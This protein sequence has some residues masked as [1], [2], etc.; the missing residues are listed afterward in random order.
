MA[1]ALSEA[2]TEGP[3]PTEAADPAAGAGVGATAGDAMDAPRLAMYELLFD[4]VCAADLPDD[5]ADVLLAAYEGDRQLA[6][7]LH[8][9]VTTRAPSARRPAGPGE[10][11]GIYLRS[12][13]VE[14]FRGIGRET[15]LPLRPGPGLTLVMGRNGSGKSSFAEAAE[16]VMTGDSFRWADRDGGAVWRGGWRNFHAGQDTETH[17]EVDLTVEGEHRPV[18][19]ERRWPAGDA[20]EDGTSTVQRAGARRELLADQDWPAI[21][22]T[23]RPF[24]SYAELGKLV[25]GRPSEMYDA[26]HAIL[27]LEQLVA[28]EA[29]LTTA[30]KDLDAR[31]KAVKQDLGRLREDLASCS[32]ERAARVAAALGGRRPDLDT[33]ESITTGTADPEPAGTLTDLT[34]ITLPTADAV[35]AQVHDL[36]EAAAAARQLAGTP[37][38]E[39]SRLADLL[40]RALEHHEAHGDGPCPVCGAGRLDQA[41]QAAT[42][43]EIDRQE[44]IA[45]AAVTTRTRLRDARDAAR[46]LLTAAPGRAHR[47]DRTRSGR[48]PRPL[49][50]LVRAAD[51]DGPGCA[52]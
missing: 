48:R 43:A 51:H 14:G 42:R 29:R 49:A 34:T 9:A 52:R 28:T 1:D 2:M 25:H 17:I 33:A 13:V 40:R 10:I 44:Q 21:L 46:A 41:W 26:L 30:R 20:L 31:A 3:A 5:V 45:A 19:V 47:P 38:E 36:R 16:L 4:R 7:A 6:E 8:G 11:A 50:G 37:P 18:T 23:Y 39:A 32:D 24:L 15:V 35:D 27:G 12:V 22:A